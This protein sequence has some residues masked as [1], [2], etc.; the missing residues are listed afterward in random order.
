MKAVFNNS[1]KNYIL[2]KT[3]NKI[4]V[5]SFYRIKQTKCY[6]GGWMRYASRLVITK[7]D[8]VGLG[9]KTGG[10]DPMNAAVKVSNK[11]TS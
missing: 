1:K 2:L 8:L 10:E 11:G 5:I 9:A 3:K 4:L 7:V 6:F